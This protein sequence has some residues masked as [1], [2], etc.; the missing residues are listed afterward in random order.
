MTVPRAVRRVSGTAGLRIRL[1]CGHGPGPDQ[2][3]RDF[4]T[5]FAIR[6]LSKSCRVAGRTQGSTHCRH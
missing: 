2:P 5:P 6:S 3:L 1:T 4:A